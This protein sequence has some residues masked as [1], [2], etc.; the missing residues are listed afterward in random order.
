MPHGGAFQ[1]VTFVLACWGA[2]LSTFVGLWNFYRDYTNKGYLRVHCYIGVAAQPGVGIVKD[3]LLVYAITNRGRQPIRV[4]Q[5]GGM[6]KTGEYRAFMVN[7]DRVPAR[8]ESGDDMLVYT[9]DL[10]VF[11]E[12]V[13]FLGA[14]DS[15]G[16]TYKVPKKT[17]EAVLNRVREI[18]TRTTTR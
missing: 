6:H 5:V 4:V 2:L 11:D 17:L 7:T 13:E 3:N 18:K 8:L 12:P 10:S 1:W 16:K 15:L 14:T 9:D